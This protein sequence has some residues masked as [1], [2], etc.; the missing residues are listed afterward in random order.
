MFELTQ[1][2][3]PCFPYQP[4]ELSSTGAHVSF[5]GY[6]RPDSYLQTQVKQLLYIA[7]EEQCR[8]EGLIIT[9]EARQQFS[10]WDVYCVQRIGEVQTHEAAIWIGTWSSRRS[11]AFDS[12]RFIL[13]E[14]KKRLYIWKKEYYIDGTSRWIHGE[15]HS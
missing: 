12:C 4:K 15:T 10:L 9:Q 14:I 6:V 11:Q 2:P 8:Q 5:S 3:I 1:K 13:E 7:D